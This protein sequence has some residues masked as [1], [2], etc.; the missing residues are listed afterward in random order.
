MHSPRPCHHV[1]ESRITPPHSIAV[2]TLIQC[3]ATTHRIA[4]QA[5]W[6][7]SAIRTARTT[8]LPDI[9]DLRRRSRVAA[10]LRRLNRPPHVSRHDSRTR[11]RSVMIPASSRLRGKGWVRLPGQYEQ[12][13][14]TAFGG[15]SRVKGRADG[16]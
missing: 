12:T 16:L 6:S 2:A 4:E 3:G 7:A 10:H 8:R 13:V 11:H 14:A 5:N 9:T 1:G 15:S